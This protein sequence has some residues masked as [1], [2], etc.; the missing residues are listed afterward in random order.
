MTGDQVDRGR[1]VARRARR[2]GPVRQGARPARS[3]PPVKRRR[4]TR[5]AR[6]A[7]RGTR[8]EAMNISR[9]FIERPVMTTLVMAAMVIFGIFGYFTLPVSELP[10]FDFP[11]IN[12]R[13][14]CPAPIPRPWPRPWRRR[15]KTSFR[16]G[17]RHRF[18]DLIERP[19][20]TPASPCS[21]AWTATSTAPPRTCRRRFPR[22]LRQL[23][24][25]MPYAAH[26]PQSQS[27]RPPDLLHRAV[28]GHGAASQG[29]SI[30]RDHAGAAAF[31]PGRRRPGQCRRRRPN[32][33]CASR[34]IRPRWRRAASA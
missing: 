20:A 9:H 29:R 24:E 25:T 33:R 14:A 27:R 34:P 8:A 12:V 11:T 22:R 28:F 13:P 3:R 7:G 32:M 10:N 6:Q 17:Q 30:C 15:W 16:H 31:H 21:S 23:P 5:A 4:Q 19:R 1:P 2:Q 18:H 26:L